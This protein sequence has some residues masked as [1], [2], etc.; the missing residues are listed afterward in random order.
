MSVCVE[1]TLYLIQSSWFW[2]CCSNSYK[3]FKFWVLLGLNSSEPRFKPRD[4]QWNWKPTFNKLFNKFNS[5]ISYHVISCYWSCYLTLYY[6]K[7]NSY[8]CRSYILNSE[9]AWI[10]SLVDPD[11]IIFA[12]LLGKS[13]NT[14]NYISY[15]CM[16]QKLTFTPVQFLW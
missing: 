1:L 8:R 14:V 11:F 13:L 9:I 15:F 4:R 2:I 12:E 10:D 16:M 6:Q 7:R 3:L 5:G